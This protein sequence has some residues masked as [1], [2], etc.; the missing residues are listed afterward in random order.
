M[1]WRNSVSV[2]WN[3]ALMDVFSPNMVNISYTLG[4]ISL[5]VEN[6]SVELTQNLLKDTTFLPY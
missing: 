1:D 6:V 4:N 5:E 2:N 3:E